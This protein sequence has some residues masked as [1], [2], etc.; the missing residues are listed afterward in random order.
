MTAE[1]KEEEKQELFQ[2]QKQQS[3]TK[4]SDKAKIDKSLL[5]NFIMD[6]LFKVLSQQTELTSR[7]FFK[8]DP[9]KKYFESGLPIDYDKI[10][11]DNTIFPILQ[12]NLTTYISNLTNKINT[13]TEVY[14][15][16]KE[17]DF[18]FKDIDVTKNKT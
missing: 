2:S 14:K 9:T 16:I 5:G 17:A 10:R 18:T 7:G 8:I 15:F 13:G 1:F 4:V 12:G 3:Q 6:T 11:N